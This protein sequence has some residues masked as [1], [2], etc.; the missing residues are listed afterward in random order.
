MSAPRPFTCRNPACGNDGGRTVLGSLNAGLL[1]LPHAARVQ[2][3]GRTWYVR[4]GACGQLA[5]WEGRVAK[6]IK[7]A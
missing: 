3:V 7:A 2:R 4:C 6:E 5:P 1:I